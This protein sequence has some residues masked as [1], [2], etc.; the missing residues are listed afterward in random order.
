MASHPRA[1]SPS[2]WERALDLLLPPRCVICGHGGAFV[3]A[4]CEASF[5]RLEPP[6]CAVCAEP[7]ASGLCERCRDAPPA[8]DGVRAP[9]RMEGGVRLVVHSLKYR[10]LTALSPELSRLMAACLADNAL[11]CDALV[12]VPL[13]PKRLRERGYNQAELLASGV[14]KLAGRP[15]RADA[16]VRARAS[17]PQV[18]VASREARVRNAEGAFACAVDVRGMALVVVDDVVTTGSTGNA[19]AAALKAQGAASVW[20]LALAREV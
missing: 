18:T 7:A 8:L 3:C 16:L 4:A 17:A 20:V 14:G 10:G 13:H 19:C 15:I 9:F 5:P 11:P 2:L 1:R 12:P 6:Y